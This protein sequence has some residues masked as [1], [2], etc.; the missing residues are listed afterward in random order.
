MNL[1]IFAAPIITDPI[2]I[3]IY[4]TIVLAGIF[5]LGEVKALNKFFRIFPPLIWT[6]F[7]PMIGT[8]L[9]ITPDSST[10]YSFMSNTL[11][12]AVLVLLIIPTDVKSIINLGPKAIGVMFSGTIGIVV[13]AIIAF[14]IGNY[15]F[16]LPA[17]TWKGVA[18]LSGSWIGGSPNMMAISESIN[19]PENIF[20]AF[21]VVDTVLAYSWLGILIALTAY[22]DQIDTFFKADNS[23]IK[24]INA[25]LS[26]DYDSHKIPLT[27][28]WLAVILGLGF[29]ISKLCMA[30]GY[31]IP[32]M[33]DV[34]THKSWG[35]IIVTTVSLLLALTKLRKID[36]AGA[37]QIGYYGLY[38]LLASIGA[39]ADLQA[40]FDVPQFFVIGLI[41][42]IIHIIILFAGMRL[43]KAPIFLFATGSMANIGGTASAP[44]VAAAYQPSMAPVGLLMA[45]IGSIAGT[46]LGFFVV[47]PL[48]QWIAGM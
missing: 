6:Y 2:S 25:K 37:S 24:A 22:Q 7:I 32:E 19:T 31:K 13:G 30:I 33:G 34:L 36:Y 23:H 18:A 16:D 10:V 39:K 46:Y 5:Y 15:L 40:I 4:F 20:G 38:L 27:L 35:I 11:L 42:L 14:G 12:P 48:C 44:V 47:A 8:T 1:K 29:G 9:G 28:K 45:V 17:E 41:W 21:V 43:F 3:F 26:V